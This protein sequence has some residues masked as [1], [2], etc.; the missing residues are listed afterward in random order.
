LE[1]SQVPE[2]SDPFV[3]MCWHDNHVHGFRIVEGEHGTGQLVLDIDYIADWR[4]V[5]N[6]FRF[7]VAPSTLSFYEIS[8]LSI[9]LDYVTPNAG[10]TPPAI[11][12]IERETRV[13]PN[14]YTSFSWRILFNWPNGEISFQSP[15]FSQVQWGESVEGSAQ[16][17]E[18]GARA[19][20]AGV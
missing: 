16:W 9:S 14:G 19:P 2:T 13:F 7:L 20:R 1:A 8:D 4:K 17:L 15:R 11:H 5:G 12:V 3:D 6:S 10:I 18:A